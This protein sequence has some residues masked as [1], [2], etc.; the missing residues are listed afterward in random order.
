MNQTKEIIERFSSKP[1][2]VIMQNYIREAYGHTPKIEFDKTNKKKSYKVVI[3]TNLKRISRVG[4][5]EPYLKTIKKR[6]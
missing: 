3:P 2:A 6:R 1:N 5:D 4:L